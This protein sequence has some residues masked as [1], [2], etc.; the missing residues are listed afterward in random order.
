M[1]KES[2]D[3]KLTIHLGQVPTCVLGDRLLLALDKK[4]L[5]INNGK[6]IEFDV[7]LNEKNQ[8]VL[9]ASLVMNQDKTNTTSG[10]IDVITN[11]H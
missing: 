4:W 8:L 2:E 9:S 1:F 5:E 11:T 3:R 7:V 10:E 6:M